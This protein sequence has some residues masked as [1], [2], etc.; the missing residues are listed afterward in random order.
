MMSTKAPVFLGFSGKNPVRKH[1][2][3]DLW[4]NVSPDLQKTRRQWKTDHAGIGAAL[5][6]QQSF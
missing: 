3:H 2:F 6:S 5:G 4:R 1:A